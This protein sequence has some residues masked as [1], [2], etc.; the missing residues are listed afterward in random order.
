MDMPLADIM[1][2]VAAAGFKGMSSAA[3]TK[4]TRIICTLGPACWYVTRHAFSIV[5]SG[6]L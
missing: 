3:Q 2:G 1:K 6:E 5:T 4:K